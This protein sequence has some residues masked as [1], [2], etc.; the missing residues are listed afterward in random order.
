[1]ILAQQD[2]EKM[3][4]LLALA[5]IEAQIPKFFEKIKKILKDKKL[6]FDKVLRIYAIVQKAVKDVEAIVAEK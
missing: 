1:M 5:A 4:G 6:T 2:K 3:T